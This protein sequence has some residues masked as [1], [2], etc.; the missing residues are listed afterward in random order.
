MK[1][2]HGP[3]DRAAVIRLYCGYRFT[4]VTIANGTQ[5]LQCS[6]GGTI[7]HPLEPPK[8]PARNA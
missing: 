5:P 7:E 4:V 3:T 6:C 2:E 1:P 8:T